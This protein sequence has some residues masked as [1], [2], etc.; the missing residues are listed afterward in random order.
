VDDVTTTG[1]SVLQVVE[2]ARV[3]GA[4]IE[5]VLTVVDRL[6]GAAANLAEHGVNL[7]PLTTADD[8]GL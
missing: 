4:I 1:S 8:Y 2:A 3:E 6:E 7:V 5:T